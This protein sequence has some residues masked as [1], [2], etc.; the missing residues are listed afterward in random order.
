MTHYKALY[1]HKCRTPLCWTKLGERRVLGPEL[2]SKTEDKVRLI[3]D[4]LKAA[5]DRQK[6]YANLKR[7]DIEYYVGDFLFLKVSPWKKVLK[8]GRKGKLSL[9]FIR[10][11]QILK[12]VRLVA[13]QLELPPELDRIYDV[14]QVSMLRWYWSDPS[15]VVSVE[16]IEV[17]SG[18]TFEEKP[19]QIID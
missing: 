13:Y 5:T 17:R 16:E 3:W 6:S 9:R 11:Y 7:R 18:L 2:V 8:F 4:H 15:H 1:G 14:F 12:R 10:P 19:V